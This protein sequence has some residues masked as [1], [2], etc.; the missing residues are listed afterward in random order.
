MGESAQSSYVEL[1]RRVIPDTLAI[2]GAGMAVPVISLI[3]VDIMLGS[4]LQPTTQ[5][6]HNKDPM[7]RQS[8]DGVPVLWSHLSNSHVH[9]FTRSSKPGEWRGGGCAAGPGSPVFTRTP[10][11]PRSTAISRKA[12]TPGSPERGWAAC[13]GGSALVQL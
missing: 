1:L 9:T 7:Q 13:A 12:P 6:L 10:V 8:K 5:G 11:E 4:G 3:L 2:A